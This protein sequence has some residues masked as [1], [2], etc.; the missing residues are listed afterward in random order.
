MEV[1]SLHETPGRAPVY[2]GILPCQKITEM[3]ATGEIASV[4]ILSGDERIQQDQIQPASIDLC[5]GDFAYPVD[6]SFL[7]G[8]G[9]KVW[10]KMRALDADFESFGMDL[11]GTKASC[12]WKSHRGPSVS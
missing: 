9:T 10:D 12:I 6:A 5:L 11:K 8:K 1:V 2:T 3:V 4:P 7:P